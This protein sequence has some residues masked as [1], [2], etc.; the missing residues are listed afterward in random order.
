MEADGKLQSL[1]PTQGGNGSQSLV[2]MMGGVRMCLFCFLFGCVNIIFTIDR[3][4]LTPKEMY[5]DWGFI[6]GRQN[7]IGNVAKILTIPNDITVE[8]DDD[9]RRVREEA[10]FQ[11][12]ENRSQDW[13]SQWESGRPLWFWDR[14]ETWKK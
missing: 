6:I 9:T 3:I 1:D 5:T 11:M 8:F 13:R 12:L 10:E 4:P 2:G 14:K 7:G